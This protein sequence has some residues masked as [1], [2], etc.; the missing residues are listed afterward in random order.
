MG[1]EGALRLLARRD[2]SHK[3]EVVFNNTKHQPLQLSSSF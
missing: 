2:V 3:G 1:A